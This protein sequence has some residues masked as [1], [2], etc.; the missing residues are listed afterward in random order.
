MQIAIKTLGLKKDWI[1]ILKDE[2]Y[3]E[4]F[5]KILDKVNNAKHESIVYPPDNLLFNA[6]KLT[7]FKQT[8][9]IILGQDPY[10]GK[11]QAMGLSFSVPKGEKIPPSLKNIYKEIYSDLG[12]KQPN[13][14]DLSY[15]AK[16][17]VLLLNS[18]LSVGAGVAN[19][20]AN[21]GWDK[22]SDAV[23]KILSQKKQNLVFMLW[24]NYAKSKANLIDTKKHLILSSAHPS[25]LARGAF[26]GCKHFSKA[27]EYLKMHQIS[28]I[29]WDLNHEI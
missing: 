29:D 3:S 1:E 26:F 8:K 28:P 5:A 18:T 22:F 13:S 2:I 24:G 25:P 11:N 6:F 21:F 12:I 20:H 19:S 23:I 10:H 7:S 16:Q 17:G 9:L 4:Y 15:W 27:N 14:G